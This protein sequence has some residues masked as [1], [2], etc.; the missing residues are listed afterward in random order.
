MY[1][2]LCVYVFVYIYTCTYVCLFTVTHRIC[3]GIR[4]MLWHC[5]RIE[6][7]IYIYTYI[8][9]YACLCTYVYVYM[10]TFKYTDVCL[11]YHIEY[12]WVVA[13]YIWSFINIKYIYTYIYTYMRVCVYMWKDT[14][15]NYICV[16]LFIVPHRISRGSRTKH[17]SCIRI[18]YIYIYIYIYIHIYVCVYICICIH[19]YI[20]YIYVCLPYHIEYAKV[21]ARYIEA[22]YI[23][24]ISIYLY[25]HMC[26]CVYMYTYTHIHTYSYLAYIECDGVVWQHIQT[27]HMYYW[28]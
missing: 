3:R 23:L 21:V 12:A 18:K 17:W 7:Y 4:T 5:I 6:I 25:I 9:I 16:C 10:Y 27:A 15:L 19:T 1:V 22:A 20:T 14:Y 13:R 8:Y 2:C 11:L 24:N 26:V 28:K